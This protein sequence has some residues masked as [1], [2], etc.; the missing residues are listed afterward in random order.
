MV[1]ATARDRLVFGLVRWSGLPFLLRE[2]VQRTRT[3]ILL[4]HEITSEELDLHLSVLCKRYNFIPLR[5][6][7]TALRSGRTSSLPP[8]SMVI[9]LDDGLRSNYALLDVFREH[10]VTPT[11]FVCS[12]IVGTNRK[13]WTTAVDDRNEIERLKRVPD[14]GR[15]EALAP[16]GYTEAMLFPERSALSDAEIIEMRDIVDFQ[17]HTVFHPILNQC[18]DERSRREIFES[19]QTLEHDFGFD[20]Y[21]LAFPNGDYSERDVGYVRDAG[22]QCALTVEAGLNDPNADPFRLRRLSISTEAS[23]SA[24]V[25]KA[26]PTL[27]QVKRHVLGR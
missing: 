7:V 10:H 13:F 22:Y 5:Q 23:E 3:T 16:L 27:R 9:T 6:Y 25:V 2:T 11:I 4:Y 18:S 8:K 24:I 19:K 26:C 20:I 1:T 12:G 17:S 21:A 15:L 14:E